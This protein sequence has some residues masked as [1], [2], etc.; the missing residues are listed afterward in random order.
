MPIVSKTR[1]QFLVL[2]LPSWWPLAPWPIPFTAGH[3]Q[4]ALDEIEGFFLSRTVWDALKTI[5]LSMPLSSFTSPAVLANVIEEWAK[6]NN[7]TPW[8]VTEPE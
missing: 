8:A 6:E 3:L 4:E 2:P 7:Q 5:F 1:A